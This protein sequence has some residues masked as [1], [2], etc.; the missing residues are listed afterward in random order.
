[1]TGMHGDSLL[2]WYFQVRQPSPHIFFL[3]EMTNVTWL[4]I[5]LLSARKTMV[6][7]KKP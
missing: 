4:R 6:F 5:P 7:G 1:M 3:R 2:D